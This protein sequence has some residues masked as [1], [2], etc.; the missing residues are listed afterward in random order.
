MKNSKKMVLLATAILLTACETGMS[1]K[2]TTTDINTN[3]KTGSGIVTKGRT[4]YSKP[5]TPNASEIKKIYSTKG[6]PG[7]YVQV[8]Y[9]KQQ[10]PSADFINRM[11]FAQL[12]YTLLEKYDNHQKNYYAL[13]GAYR[14]YNGAKEM[15]GAAKEYVSSS[16]FIVKVV[17]P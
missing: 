12:P 2:G 11:R 8:G 13:V 7:Y 10:K 3:E 5:S 9:F 1:N 14:S 16:A 6:T 4:T 17:R 15:L